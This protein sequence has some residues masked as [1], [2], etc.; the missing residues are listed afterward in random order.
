MMKF[1]SIFV[2]FLMTLALLASCK[3]DQS[4]APMPE[5]QIFG[6]WKVINPAVEARLLVRPDSTFHVDVLATTGI[7]AEGNA[8]VGANNRITFVNT[9][10]TDSVAA[11]PVP[12]VYD[13][14]FVSDTLRFT[15]VSD[16]LGRRIGLL[17][18]PWVPVE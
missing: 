4:P 9:G 12:G 14:T 2:A 5:N 18:S 6:H 1:F 7:E 17:S 15:L 8:T 11:N 16:T 13:Y 3:D 10:G